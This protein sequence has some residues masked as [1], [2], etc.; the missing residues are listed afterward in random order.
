M[1]GCTSADIKSRLAAK[2][3]ASESVGDSVRIK[4]SLPLRDAVALSKDLGSEGFKVQV[5][6]GNGA[7]VDAAPPSPAAPVESGGETWYRVRVGGYPD[8]AAALT[9]MKELQDK[10]YQPFIARGRE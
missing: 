9:V 10:G 8:R 1:S 3:L 4:P 2:G 6:R 7:P 5:H